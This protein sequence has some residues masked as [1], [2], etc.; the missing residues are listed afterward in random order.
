MSSN[1]NFIGKIGKNNQVERVLPAQIGTSKPVRIPKNSNSAVRNIETTDEFHETVQTTYEW[2]HGRNPLSSIENNQNQGQSQPRSNYLQFRSKR[3]MNQKNQ[4]KWDKT[5]ATRER[6]QNK[7][8]LLYYMEDHTCSVIQAVHSGIQMDPYDR[9]E[10]EREQTIE[11]KLEEKNP[12]RNDYMWSGVV[13]AIGDKEYVER[14]AIYNY[15]IIKC[16]CFKCLPKHGPLW[17]EPGP[18]EL[19]AG[20]RK[21]KIDKFAQNENI[22]EDNFAQNENIEVENFAQNEIIEVENFAQNENMEINNF[23]QNNFAEH[24]YFA[25]N[26]EQQENNEDIFNKDPD[27]EELCDTENIEPDIHPQNEMIIEQQ[28]NDQD[29][30]GMDPDEE[31]LYATVDPNDVSYNP[32]F[33]MEELAVN[34]Q[35]S[36]RRPVKRA[37]S[38][39][40]NKN[41]SKQ[42]KGTSLQDPR[43]RMLVEVRRDLR[44]AAQ[45]QKD[46]ASKQDQS[47]KNMENHILKL[48][49]LNINEIKAAMKAVKQL[50]NL[51]FL[52]TALF[53]RR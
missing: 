1:R 4:A 16:L 46:A 33:E 28:E 34:S 43:D 35:K 12:N 3:R 39:P 53:T 38:T 23:A 27:E 9:T 25:R 32:Y 36:T 19:K 51:K 29:I 40:A 47:M 48:G 22:E 11:I 13:K 52:R 31:G 18:L 44:I 37:E 7:F 17:H 41:K 49:I 8:W 5:S 21:R 30:Y 14:C 6:L 45:M 50:V 24:N 10:V 26:I 20:N 15:Y 2:N 42:A